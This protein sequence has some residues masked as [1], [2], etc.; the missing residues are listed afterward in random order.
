M[1]RCDSKINLRKE[2]NILVRK[3]LNNFI[4]LHDRKTEFAVSIQIKYAALNNEDN[5]N[6]EEI[7]EKFSEI[8][9][10]ATLEV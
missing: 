9:R 1:V 3:P 7:N 2:R 5:L 4:D 10:E 8:L 6:I